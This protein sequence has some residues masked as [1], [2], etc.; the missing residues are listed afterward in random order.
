MVDMPNGQLLQPTEGAP[1]WFIWH[2]AARG[3][4]LRGAQNQADATGHPQE[5]WMHTSLMSEDVAR[6]YAKKVIPFQHD[7][8]DEIHM[9]QFALIAVIKRNPRRADAGK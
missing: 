8:D 6:R 7:P 5:I 9:H 2:N 1:G 3:D 4:I